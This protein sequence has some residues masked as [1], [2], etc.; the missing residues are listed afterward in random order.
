MSIQAQVLDI[1]RYLLLPLVV[2]LAV[3]FL[4]LFK[5]IKKIKI[6]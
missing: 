5:K 2:L 1:T 4:I 6:I 3:F